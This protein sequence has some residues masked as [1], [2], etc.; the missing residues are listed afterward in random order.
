M[1]RSFV[2]ACLRGSIDPEVDATFNDGLAAQ[3]AMESVSNEAA[4]DRWQTIERV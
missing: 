1:M 2:D 3:L 4:Q